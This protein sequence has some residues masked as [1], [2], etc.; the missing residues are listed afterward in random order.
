MAEKIIETIKREAEKQYETILQVRRDLHQHPELSFEEERTSG[1]VK[2]FL[3]QHQI[4]FTD[5]WAGHGVVA[6]I[7]GE[8]HGPMRML[9]AD[10]DALPIQ[11]V[12]EVAYKSVNPG[13]MHACGHD[14]HTSCVL[15]AAAILQTLKKDLAG[16]VKLV[17]QPGEEKL[18]VARR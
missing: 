16:T 6:T 11:E 10:M 5:G 9:R 14:V 2:A 8:Q 1:K 18:R 7:E 3:S 12:N 13:V 4:P 17:F 15:G